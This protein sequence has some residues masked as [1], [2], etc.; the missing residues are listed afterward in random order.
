MGAPEKQAYLG[1]FYDRF[2]VEQGKVYAPSSLYVIYSCVNH[3]FINTYG[4]KLNGLLKLNRYLKA[5]TSTYVCK[6]S[7]VFSPEEMDRLLMC[8]QESNEHEMTLLGVGAA[9]MYYGLLRISDVKKVKI[10]DVSQDEKGRIVVK[11]VHARKRKNPGFTYLIPSLY[12][13]LFLKYESELSTELTSSSTYLH[14]FTKKA[15]SRKAPL[16]QKYIA[17]LVTLACKVLGKDPFGYTGHAFRRSAA[18]N[19]ADAGV[20]FVNLKRHGQWQSDSVCEGYIAN[21]KALQ[22]ERVQYLLPEKRRIAT[23]SNQQQQESVPILSKEQLRNIFSALDDDSSSDDGPRLIDLVK[24]RNKRNKKSNADPYPEE[25][26]YIKTVPAPVIAIVEEDEPDPRPEPS[27]SNNIIAPT[28]VSSSMMD[29]DDS[30][31]EEN[32]SFNDFLRHIDTGNNGGK[33]NGT[34]FHNCTFNLNN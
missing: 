3:W 33:K 8:C 26:Q 4:F 12:K 1:Q 7:R 18:T 6:K 28:I 2:F 15:K 13:K 23:T 24:K 29:A 31:K 27:F 16:G 25:V 19:L 21:S 9:L 20:S 32:V 10:E 14:R 34:V 11:F 17:N 5:M 30:K 22:T